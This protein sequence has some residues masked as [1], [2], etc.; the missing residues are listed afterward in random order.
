MSTFHD[1]VFN[2]YLL[3]QFRSN[4]PCQSNL[5]QNFMLF[6]L[7]F[8]NDLLNLSLFKSVHSTPFAINCLNFWNKELNK[9]WHCAFIFYDQVN[10]ILVS[11]AECYTVPGEKGCVLVEVSD[12]HQYH[13]LSKHPK[14]RDKWTICKLSNLTKFKTRFDDFIVNKP[15]STFLFSSNSFSTEGGSKSCFC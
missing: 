7:V 15:S 2:I 4:F 13:V 10:V 3:L 6:T 14:A 9:H 5:I 12:V 8:F 11:D 1:R